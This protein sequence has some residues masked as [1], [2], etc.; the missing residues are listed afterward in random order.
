MVGNMEIRWMEVGVVTEKALQFLIKEFLGLRVLKIDNCEGITDFE[1]TGMS[2]VTCDHL[3]EGK[4]SYMEYL[5]QADNEIVG[6][7][8]SSLKCKSVAFVRYR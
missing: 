5:M 3:W 2:A 6:L 7:P 4:N 8:L 1:V